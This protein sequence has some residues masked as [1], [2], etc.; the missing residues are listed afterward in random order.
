MQKVL[1]HHRLSLSTSVII[2]LFKH[3]ALS[4]KYSTS[5]QYM[6]YSNL[7][8]VCAVSERR[9]GTYGAMKVI[10]ATLR[11]TIPMT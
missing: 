5:E 10:S 2:C 9:G 3:G 1:T 7:S 11:E 4:F 8:F 6:I